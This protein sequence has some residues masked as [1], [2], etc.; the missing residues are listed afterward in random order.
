MTRSRRGVGIGADL[1][2][3]GIEP[4]QKG[5]GRT[6]GHRGGR[7]VQSIIR[8]EDKGH[9][10]DGDRPP[11]SVEYDSRA[12]VHGGRFTVESVPLTTEIA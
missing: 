8:R 11:T 2:R 12:E 6:P 10:P 3:G 1:V 5:W 7:V 9:R 4:K